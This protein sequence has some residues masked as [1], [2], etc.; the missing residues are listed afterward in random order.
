[1]AKGRGLVE[2]R[3]FG[4]AEE[5]VYDA[6]D[7]RGK[8]LDVDAHAV[9]TA[10]QRGGVVAAMRDG[11]VEGCTRDIGFARIRDE[12]VLVWEVG[13]QV[14]QE[15]TAGQMLEAFVGVGDFPLQ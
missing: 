14:S 3:L 9:A 5:L 2:E 8:G 6:L 13:E 10:H 1:M 4:R 12:D 7:A 11:E 15:K